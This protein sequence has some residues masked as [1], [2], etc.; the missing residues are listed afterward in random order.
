VL[1]NSCAQMFSLF[2]T[3][4]WMDREDFEI[5]SDVTTTSLRP[6]RGVITENGRERRPQ[7]RPR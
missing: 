4:R 2:V 6:T 7:A 5:L 3:F 1:R